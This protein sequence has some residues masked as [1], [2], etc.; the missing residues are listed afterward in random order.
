MF[1]SFEF[2][3]LKI[4][5]MFK[6]PVISTYIDPIPAWSNSYGGMNGVT[7]GIGSGLLRNLYWKNIE[8]NVVCADFV[9]NGSLAIAWYTATEYER[10]IFE[11]KIYHINRA[12]D[13]A[14]YF[15][16]FNYYLAHH[17]I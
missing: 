9:T 13:K 11:P 12:S 5:L 3:M 16:K 4:V 14:L 17:F 8:L 15:G 2:P 6:F 10:T 7:V 1:V